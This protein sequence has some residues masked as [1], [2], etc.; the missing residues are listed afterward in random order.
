MHKLWVSHGIVHDLT[1]WEKL[2]TKAYSLTTAS[3]SAVI[4]RAY[5]DFSGPRPMEIDQ[6]VG[7]DIPL[8]DCKDWR[9]ILR[10][11]GEKEELVGPAVKILLE[12][13]ESILLTGTD[14]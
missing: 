14:T 1:W 6:S 11:T 8:A 7:V 10:N 3:G 2:W 12:Y 13:A 5:F 9:L 4:W